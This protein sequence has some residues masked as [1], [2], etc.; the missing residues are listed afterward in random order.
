MRRTDTILLPNIAGECDIIA[1]GE[2]PVFGD[3]TP[4][5]WTAYATVHFGKSL[6]MVV[7]PESITGS[8]FGI[9]PAVLSRSFNTIIHKQVNLGHTL[10]ALGK[11][12]DRICGCVLQCAF[13]EE[14]SGGWVVPA[15]VEE[16]PQITAFSALFKQARGVPKMLGDHLGGKVK[17]SVSMEFTYYLDEMGLYDPVS[18]MTYDRKDIPTSLSGYWFEDEK[19]R[20]ML[21]KSSRK[22]SLVVA[23]GG[24]SG[25][26]WFSG[27]GYTDRPAE[28]TAGIDSIAAARHNE[29]L[30]VCGSMLELPE[31]VPGMKVRWP[32]GEFGHGAV[33]TVYL[34]GKH[35]RFQKTLTATMENPV[36]DIALPD[37][38]RIIRRASSVSKKPGA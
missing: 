12:E 29:G 18:N 16:A 20:L 17:M 22:P 8:V 13:P 27:Y 33:R 25:R 19:G 28:S 26:V 38:R 2:H 21:K 30:M 36:L 4:D 1:A 35:T 6:P 10:V 11:K 34:D 23:L 5:Q 7:G 15:T 3:V 31:F 32:G 24:V 14:P 37:G 9:H